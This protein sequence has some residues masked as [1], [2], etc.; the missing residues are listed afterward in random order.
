M[1]SKEMHKRSIT[2]SIIW[3]I[4]GVIVLASVTYFYT[5]NLIT[6]SLV[7]FLHHGIFLFVYYINERFFEH[8]DYTGF[9]RAFVKML[10][11]ETIL[12]TFILGIITLIIT[13]NVQTMTKITLTYI[14][15]KHIMYLMNEFFIWSKIEWGLK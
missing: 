3:R 12:G 13:G 10:C 8:I 7:T 5:N 4:I 14:C 15:I 6:V 9:K 11:Y 1:G 2:K